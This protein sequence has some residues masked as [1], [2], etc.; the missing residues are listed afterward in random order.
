MRMRGMAKRTARR[1]WRGLE[2][3]DVARGERADDASASVEVHAAE[4]FETFYLREFPG[5]VALARALA[6]DVHA[7]DIA[8]EALLVAYGKWQEVAS[9]PSP[10]A[11]VRGVCAKKAMSSIRRSM[12]ESRALNRL[13]LTRSPAVAALPAEDQTFWR[14]VR[15]LPERQAQVVALFYVVDMSVADVAM[16]LKCAEGTVK[17]HLSRARATL[18]QRLGVDEG[19]QS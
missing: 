19:V 17:T 12:A 14:E 8:Q 6:G 11:W 2:L 7:Q 4:S 3:V 1:E 9:Y 16:T 18:A 15:D 10:A 5:L 13:R